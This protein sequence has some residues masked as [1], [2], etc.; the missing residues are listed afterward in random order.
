[1]AEENEIQVAER[2]HESGFVDGFDEQ[3]DLLRRTVARET[4]THEPV[5]RAPV[6]R[7]L[8]I[9][10][11]VVR[12][13]VKPH[14]PESIQIRAR[15]TFVP[16]TQLALS[17]ASI[18][19]TDSANRKPKKESPKESV[20]AAKNPSVWALA[21]SKPP[22]EKV[23][24]PIEPTIETLKQSTAQKHVER[25]T[26]QPNMIFDTE[27]IFSREEIRERATVRTPLSR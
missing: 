19:Q 11:P 13:T 8:V 3:V 12:K 18:D 5:V 10:E 7:E 6:V 23:R 15:R 27:V 21:G 24:A 4:A 2:G 14:T 25:G 17:R 16:Q 22:V 9:R 20:F 1:V 26:A